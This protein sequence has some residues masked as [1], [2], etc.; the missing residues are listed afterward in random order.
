MKVNIID[1]WNDHKPS[2]TIDPFLVQFLQ[3]GTFEFDKVI[4]APNL[5]G[6]YSVMLNNEIPQSKIEDR[7]CPNFNGGI[8]FMRK[9]KP[10]RLY[11]CQENDVVTKEI[12]HKYGME[13]IYAVLNSNEPI[14][15]TGKSLSQLLKEKGIDVF[16][17]E[18]VQSK[19]VSA[20]GYV[21]KNDAVLESAD[22]MSIL[23]S[24]T[25]LDNVNNWETAE[26][27]PNMTLK[28]GVVADDFEIDIEHQGYIL[29]VKQNIS[30]LREEQQGKKLYGIA[31]QTGDRREFL[32]MVDYTKNFTR[33]VGLIPCK[34]TQKIDLSKSLLDL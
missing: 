10:I 29:G 33:S 13:E 18:N 25:F 12:G 23:K 15:E 34:D 26:F 20:N 16:E 17:D 32:K 19:F 11:L 3:D 7:V 28:L 1:L 2:Q 30:G 22:C 31:L 27:Y 8:I 21:S 9:G 14:G 4:L 5:V 24:S 6:H